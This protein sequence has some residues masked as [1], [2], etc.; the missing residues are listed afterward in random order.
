MIKI[1][2]VQSEYVYCPKTDGLVAT[3]LIQAYW[4]KMTLS[5]RCGWFETEIERKKLNAKEL[6]EYAFDDLECN[7]G[8]YT[9]M[10]RL[11]MESITEEEITELQNLLNR[12]CDKFEF[13]VYT[14]TREISPELDE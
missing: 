6:L 4:N 9:D 12:I 13:D 3:E 10:A 5:H 14:A 1:K 11:C 7:E 8:G 2:D